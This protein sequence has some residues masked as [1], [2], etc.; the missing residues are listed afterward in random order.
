LTASQLRDSPRVLDQIIVL[1]EKRPLLET[2]LKE[3]LYGGPH[4]PRV[5][6]KLGMG[7]VA[8]LPLNGELDTD[9]IARW[10]SSILLPLGDFPSVEHWVQTSTS[11]GTRIEL[12]LVS[13]TPYF[14]S[15]CPH[16]SSVKAPAGSLIGGGIGCSGLVLGMDPSEFGNET[17]LT[18][19]GGEGAQWIGMAPSSTTSTS[20]K[21]WV[22]APITIQPAWRSG[23]ASRQELT[24]HTSCCATRRSQ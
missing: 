16:N 2:A 17:G 18:Q 3:I 6:G 14:C 9:T 4:S 21:M 5:I 19:M 7:P 13:R 20:S 23:R 24:S 15:G 1:E 10:L 22:T 11:I 8:T 12:P